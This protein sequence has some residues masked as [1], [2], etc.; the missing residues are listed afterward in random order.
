MSTL[1]R[2][3]AM[4]PPLDPSGDEARSLLRRELAHPDYHDRNPFDVTLDWLD[5]TLNGLLD[6][7]RGA[8]PLSTFAAI[9]A[10]LLLGLA[11]AWLLSRARRTPRAAGRPGA[12]VDDSSLT[13]A[14]LRARAERALADGRNAEA[15]VDGFRALTVRQV[16][17]GWLDDRPGATA[18]EVAGAL[19]TTYPGQRGRVAGSAALFDAVRYG[20]RPATHD[21]AADV[22]ALDDALAGRR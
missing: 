1:L 5:R 6:G 19:A 2:A 15:L 12:V 7:A 17:R 11:L 18:H 13:A 9:V 10:F 16:E 21:Q 22:L 20:D 14:E 3:L 8:P 4:E